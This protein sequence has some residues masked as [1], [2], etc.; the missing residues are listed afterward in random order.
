[1]SRGF[2]SSLFGWLAVG[3]LSTGW[4]QGETAV[5]QAQAQ[6]QAQAATRPTAATPTLS[7]NLSDAFRQRR[8]G[9]SRSYEPRRF[10]R[11]ARKMLA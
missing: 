1:M 8:L 9:T 5:P 6:A 10:F 3:L 4:Q 2:R 7:N 11:R